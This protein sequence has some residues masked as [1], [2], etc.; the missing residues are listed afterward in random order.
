MCKN[1]CSARLKA[2]ILL[3]TAPIIWTPFPLLT[4][5]GKNYNHPQMLTHSLPWEYEFKIKMVQEQWLKLN[6]WGF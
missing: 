5:Y 1:S 2:I 3:P 4:I 6:K